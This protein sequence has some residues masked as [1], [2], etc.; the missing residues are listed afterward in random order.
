MLMHKT[1][2]I[3]SR[4]LSTRKKMKK[5][6]IYTTSTCAYCETVK[7]WLGSKGL[8][9]DVV[10]MDDKPDVRQQIIELSGAMTV[11]I[12][13]VEDDAGSKNL[14]VGWNPSKLA[15]AVA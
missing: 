5:I 3:L 11:P 12:T 10:N 14:I 15:S 1:L 4:R 2:Y 13:V 6:T 8:A 7:K 9:Y